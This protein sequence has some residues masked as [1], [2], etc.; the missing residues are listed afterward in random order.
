MKAA[1]LQLKTLIQEGRV[2]KELFTP[3]QLRDIELG[4][5][6]I[7][8]LTWHHHQ[9]VTRMQLIEERIHQKVGHVG[10]MNVWPFKKQ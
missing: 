9:D 3:Q 1:T 10:G 4:K 2:K 7:K 5:A 8:G 6:K